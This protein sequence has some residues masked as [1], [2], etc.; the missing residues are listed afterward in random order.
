M[1]P[2]LPP[3][4]A[5]EVIIGTILVAGLF[6]LLGLIGVALMPFFPGCEGAL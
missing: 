2:R 4:T 5:S 6:A 3:L 1:R